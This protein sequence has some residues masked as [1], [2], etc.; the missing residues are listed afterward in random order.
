MDEE[1]QS[2]IIKLLEEEPKFLTFDKHTA[3]HPCGIELW[4]DN[5]PYA[6]LYVYSPVRTKRIKGFFTRIKVRKLIEKAKSKL[7]LEKI[8]NYGKYT[9]S[10]R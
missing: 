6:D 10:I 9:N 3:F 2:K 1:L 4:I 5:A 8:N 7:V